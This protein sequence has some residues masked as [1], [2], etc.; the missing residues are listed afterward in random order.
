LSPWCA[1]IGREF[2]RAV[3]KD[4]DRFH[5]ELDLSGMIRG[6]YPTRE[7]GINAV[8]AGVLT[9][10]ELRKRW[11]STRTPMATSCCRKQ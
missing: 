6:N 5:L 11:A 1:A 4:P 10:D 3:F 9:P 2:A 7:V 8:R